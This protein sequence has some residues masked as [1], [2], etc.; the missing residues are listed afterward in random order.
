MHGLGWGCDRESRRIGIELARIDGGSILCFSPL[1]RRG[2]VKVENVERAPRNAGAEFAHDDRQV[3]AA[4][5]SLAQGVT[6]KDY[7]DVD[8]WSSPIFFLH[9]RR[10]D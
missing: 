5:E 10:P 2:N 1:G 6:V 9:S 4:H 7:G 3:G 8:R